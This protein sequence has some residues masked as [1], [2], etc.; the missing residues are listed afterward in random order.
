[1]AE[2]PTVIEQLQRKIYK[3]GARIDEYFLDFDKLRTG[4]VTKSQF[5]R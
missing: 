5:A 1:M 3:R 2:L 4:C